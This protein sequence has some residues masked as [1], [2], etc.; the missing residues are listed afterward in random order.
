MLEVEATEDF[1]NAV[2][3]L[4]EQE[5]LRQEE[6]ERM[7]IRRREELERIAFEKKQEQLRIEAEEAAEWARRE[8]EKRLALE[9]QRKEDEAHFAIYE[10]VLLGFFDELEARV[11]ERRG[12]VISK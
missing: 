2:Q 11:A 9:A 1:A 10:S 4:E 7:L 5:R 12:G 3:I 6:H 8:E